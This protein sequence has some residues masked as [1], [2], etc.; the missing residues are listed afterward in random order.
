[1]SWCSPLIERKDV[2]DFS[3]NRPPF[4]LSAHLVTLN[5]TASPNREVQ[6]PFRCL[7]MQR[8]AFIIIKRQGGVRNVLLMCATSALHTPMINAPDLHSCLD[9]YTCNFRLIV[10]LGFIFVILFRINVQA[11]SKRVWLRSASHLRK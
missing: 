4:S 5:L 2:L 8:I 3:T 10:P 9:A 11:S 6:F 1:M 7:E